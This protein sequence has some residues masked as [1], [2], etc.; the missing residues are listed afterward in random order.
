M[1]KSSFPSRSSKIAFVTIF[2]L[3]LAGQIFLLLKTGLGNYAL[4]DAYIVEH[5]V[6]GILSGNESRFI[7]ATPWD[8]VTSP[9]YVGLVTLMSFLLPVELSHW[10]VSVLSTM[11]LMSGWFLLCRRHC[12]G[13]VVTVAVVT[14]CLLVG[15][16]YYQLTNGLETGL[17]MAAFTWI[18][19]ALDYDQPPNWG[20]ALAGILYFVRPELAALS[21]IFLLWIANKHP[22]GWRRGIL[23]AFAFFSVPFLLF[24][25]V[26]GTVVPNTLSAKVYFFAE[27]C[28][29]D[30]FRS[31]F[32]LNA[33]SNFINSLGLFSVGFAFALLSRH[34]LVLF[35]FLAL[36]LFA[37]FERFPGALFHNHF[38]YLYLLM[39][40][41]ILG[42]IACLAHRH[43]IVRFV[44]GMFGIGVLVSTLQSLSSTLDSY[45][46]AVKGVSADNAG[47]AY[48]VAHNVPPQAVVMVHDAGKISRIGE[49]PLMDLVGLKSPYSTEVHRRKTFAKCVRDPT[50]ISDIARYA[51]ASYMVVT[52]DWDSI[53]ALTNSLAHTGWTVERA[54]TGR[55]DTHYKVYK[56]TDGVK[57]AK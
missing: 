28:R 26:T 19:V 36:F 52:K 44:G 17:A 5:S 50:A 31:I 55:G 57:I 20:Y 41:A 54:D 14:I 18:L 24:F 22:L 32:V 39:P 9:V 48:W 27:G 2:S 49:Q 38:R 12:L 29:K 46:E 43:R 25:W 13:S 16:T 35:S 3:V 10:I 51:K 37:Y 42:W 11:L 56:I 33:L 1:F 6:S 30:S 21:A 8:G 47:M 15:M 7:G 23:I 4:D 34:R 53:F 40:I 45:V